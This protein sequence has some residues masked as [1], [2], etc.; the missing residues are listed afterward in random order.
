V[1]SLKEAGY[2]INIVVAHHVCQCVKIEWVANLQDTFK[3]LRVFSMSSNT[4]ISN[5]FLDVEQLI[6]LVA[7]SFRPLFLLPHPRTS[8]PP[9][10]YGSPTFFTLHAKIFEDIMLSHY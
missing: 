8:L 7:Q 6:G 4:L 2:A 5:K 3:Q 10:L 1:H 9:F